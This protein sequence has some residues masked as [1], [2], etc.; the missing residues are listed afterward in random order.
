MGGALPQEGRE[1][2]RPGFLSPILEVS[3][4]LQEEPAEPDKGPAG[5]LS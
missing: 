1:A 2:W 4:R 5:A 3:L